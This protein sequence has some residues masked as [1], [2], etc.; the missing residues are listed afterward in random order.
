MGWLRCY[1]FGETY[2]SPFPSVSWRSL[3]Q[4]AAWVVWSCPPPSG[5]GRGSSSG[6]SV[7]SNQPRGQ[8]STWSPGYH[9]L[10]TP[11]SSLLTPHSSQVLLVLW[12]W[13]GWPER[14]AGWGPPGARWGRGP[15]HCP[16]LPAGVWALS[17]LL[18][19]LAKICC[20]TICLSWL[21][22]LLIEI[23]WI[24]KDDDTEKGIRNKN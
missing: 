15:P 6:C 10:L 5:P 23:K 8:G 7:G 11:H 19:L 3:H 21:T 9:S 1:S 20:D 4:E 12:V 22:Q 24:C 18:T 16:R 14:W 17:G 13:L 2:L